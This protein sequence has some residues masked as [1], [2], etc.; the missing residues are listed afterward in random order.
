M[1]GPTPPGDAASNAELLAEIHSRA[2]DHPWGAE[3]IRQLLEM[4]GVFCLDQP[5][6]FILV[7]GVVDEAEIL[8]LAVD[9]AFRRQG[10]GSALVRA[11]MQ[12][13]ARLG[14]EVMHLEVADTNRAALALYETC[15]FV[16]TGRRRDYYA[17]A[18]GL[19]ADAITMARSLGPED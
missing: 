9:P 14:A 19:R 1:T 16:S 8:T 17:L 15:G 10:L 6:G 4:P 3:Q 5:G 12:H 7:R 2:F 18:D 13:A 11:A